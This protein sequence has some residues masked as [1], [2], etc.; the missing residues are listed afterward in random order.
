MSS[1]IA[2]ERKS[3]V[4]R[5]LIATHQK[6]SHGYRIDILAEHFAK[7]ILGLGRTP[8]QE[9][10]RVLDVGCGDM[11]LADAVAA[12]LGAV[13][14][15]CVD[16]HP[17]PPELLRTDP[18]WQRYSRFDGVHLPF[19]EKSFDVVMFSDVLHHVPSSIRT[20]LLRSAA[21]VGRSIIIK[22]H[23][24]YGWWSRQSLR[25]MDWVGNFGY[26]V[27]IPDRYFDRESLDRQ[28]KEAQISISQIDI[29]LPLYD[30][31]PVVRSLL[32]PAWQFIAICLPAGMQTGMQG[33]EVHSR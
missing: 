29:G 2:K 16:I 13:D 21:K 8:G 30:H 14:F 20:P 32:S 19:D 28:C 27:S 12:K 5:A 31:L 6:M 4:D 1:P 10:V 26:G 3:S 25:A 17:C 22:D 11:T 18:R 33:G 9:T 7:R 23:L 24:E 15:R